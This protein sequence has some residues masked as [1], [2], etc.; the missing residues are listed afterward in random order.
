MGVLQIQRS[1]IESHERPRHCFEEPCTLSREPIRLQPGNRYSQRGK[2]QWSGTYRYTH[3]R[4]ARIF[5]QSLLQRFYL[6][7][8]SHFQRQGGSG[9]RVNGLEGYSPEWDGICKSI[10]AAISEQ[11]VKVDAIESIEYTAEELKEFMDAMNA[12]ITEK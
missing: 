4:H 7:K 1:S 9:D 11:Q 12:A 2:R 5:R 6:D 10:Q 3:N 8:E